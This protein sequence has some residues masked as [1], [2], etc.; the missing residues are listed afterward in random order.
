MHP[1]SVC[2]I[3]IIL[4]ILPLYLKLYQVSYSNF[5]NN[6]ILVGA[7]ILAFIVYYNQNYKPLIR[8][9]KLYL[10]TLFGELFYVVDKK[11]R[12]RKPDIPDLR[13]NI[14]PIKRKRLYPWNRYLI[15]DFYEGNYS[16]AEKQQEYNIDIGCCGTA[17]KTND[18]TYYDAKFYHETLKG[19]TPTQK[20]ITRKIGSILTTPIYSPK[21]E[22]KKW[23][24]AILNIDST[25]GISVT[26]FNESSIQ[27]IAAKRAALIGGLLI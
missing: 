6:I 11:I 14:M 1:L 13:I 3:L 22:A 18:Q 9:Q 16:E 5:I 24:I 7:F 21:D 17:V 25:S 2:L 10:D 26:G 23:P 4:Y 8:K 12:E 19:M 27:D 15:I 20:E